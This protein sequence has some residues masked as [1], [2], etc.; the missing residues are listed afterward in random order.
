MTFLEK[1]D[2]IKYVINIG[3][4][5]INNDSKKVGIIYV[6]CYMCDIYCTY[7]QN[8]GYEGGRDGDGHVLNYVTIVTL[9]NSNRLITMFPS[10]EIMVERNEPA[11]GEQTNQDEE[12]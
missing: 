1:F 6:F 7:V 9:P 2:T 5:Y 10:D 12:R 11:I 4:A 8:C 3:N